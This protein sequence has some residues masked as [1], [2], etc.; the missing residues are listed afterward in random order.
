MYWRRLKIVEGG[1]DKFKQEY[2]A[3]ADE[4]FLVSGSSVFNPEKVNSMIPSN[5]KSVRAYNEDTS[6]F[7]ESDRGDLKLWVPPNWEENYIIAADVAL[8]VKQDYSCA[9]VLDIEGKVCALYRCNTIDPHKYGELLFYLGRYYNN[10]LLAVESNSM[11][12]ATLQRLKQM[13]YVNLYYETKAARLSHEETETPGF[14]M[15]HGSKPRVIG[16]LKNAV[17]EDDLW[18][19]SREIIA[20]MKT[21]VSNEQGKTEALPGN[22]DDTVMALAIAWEVRRTHMDKLSN[23][24]ISWRHKWN[25]PQN[26]DQWI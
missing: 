14:R 4:A 24:K 16:Q 8:G 3:N 23:N 11:G 12:I 22:H 10:A 15:T 6:S 2:P 9:V 13:D 20:E 19:P 1:E 25:L 26:N 21:Y 5:P 17:E 18:I 7:D